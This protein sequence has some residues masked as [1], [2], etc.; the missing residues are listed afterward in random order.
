MKRLAAWLCL[1]P[2]LALAKVPDCTNPNAWPAGMALGQ[3]Q[4]VGLIK[5]A[6]DV[7]W[8]KVHV[9]RLASE[10]VD[11]GLWKQIHLI[12]FTMKSGEQIEV[13]TNHFASS[14]ECSES[15]VEVFI[16]SKRLGSTKR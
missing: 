10:Q 8:K 15:D 13:I 11:K 6:T 1:V 14:Q 16:V 4:D 3:L 9:Q 5:S 2:V 7:D 12:T